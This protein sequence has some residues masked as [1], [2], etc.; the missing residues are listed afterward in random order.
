MWGE[1]NGQQAQ[2]GEG[3]KP[4]MTAYLCQDLGPGTQCTEPTARHWEWSGSL[5]QSW[6][7]TQHSSCCTK[8]GRGSLAQRFRLGGSLLL[9]NPRLGKEAVITMALATPTR[10]S[11]Q[12]PTCPSGQHWEGSDGGWGFFTL[13]ADR[14]AVSHGRGAVARR[15]TYTCSWA[16]Q[17]PA[18][19]LITIKAHNARGNKASFQNQPARHPGDYWFPLTLITSE[20]IDLSASVTTKLVFAS[21]QIMPMTAILNANQV[22]VIDMSGKWS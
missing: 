22:S 21:V 6:T 17:L 5:L 2:D 4:T 13:E 8:G 16:F 9:R 3:E 15:C 12:G 20:E 14:C 1:G 10:W 7:W 11:L 19:W 18:S